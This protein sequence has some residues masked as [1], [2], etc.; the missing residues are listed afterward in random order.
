L[1]ALDE[2]SVAT[3]IERHIGI[4]G[5]PY[6]S[7]QVTEITLGA[8]AQLR[9]YKVQAEGEGG[10]HLA[11]TGVLA[12][13]DA[14]YE[15]FVLALGARLARHET[16]VRL[17]GARAST[18][19]AGAYLIRGRQHC[20]HT[21]VIEHVAPHTRC[22]EVFKGVVDEAARAVFQGRIVVGRGAHGSDGRQLSKALL[23]S[24]TA[25]VDQKPELEIYNDDVKCSHGA[26]AGQ[27]D[28]DQLFYLQSRGL[29]EASARRLLIEGFL[30]E[31][32]E[33]ISH[34][35]VREALF[36]HALAR[37]RTEGE[38]TS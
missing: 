30:G 9:H 31:A 14:S 8:R 18:V 17:E 11:R 36:E 3:V 15:S 16:S 33:Q 12:G 29:A 7:N 35:C 26:A 20:D 34:L 27:I 21:T 32:F 6:L 24:D 38:A 25:E 23:L 4:G 5:A 22:Q 19:V 2:G 28:R 37:L 13:D 1:I 10:Y